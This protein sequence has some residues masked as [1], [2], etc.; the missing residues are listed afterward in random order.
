MRSRGWEG[1]G[2]KWILGGEGI[3]SVR[4]REMMGIKGVGVGRGMS[5]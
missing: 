1:Y 5:G 3:R 2:G 4:K